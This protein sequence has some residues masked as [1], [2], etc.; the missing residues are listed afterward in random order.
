MRR[1]APP[2]LAL[3]LG[4][5]TAFWL[6]SCGGQD[7]QLLPGN[8][9]REITENLDRVRQYAGEGEC[10]GAAD[11]AQEVGAQ[12]KSLEGVDATLKRALEQ[13]TTR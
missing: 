3:A 11:A 8:T 2:A 7:A 12:V 4:A 1:L 5:A 10:V 9:A 6:V 13:G